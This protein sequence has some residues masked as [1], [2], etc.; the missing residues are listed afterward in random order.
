MEKPKFNIGKGEGT[1]GLNNSLWIKKFGN[2][3]KI[4]KRGQG[5][6]TFEVGEIWEI[7]MYLRKFGKRMAFPILLT[8]V[9]MI[10]LWQKYPETDEFM[11]RL[12]KDEVTNEEKEQIRKDYE[13]KKNILESLE[14]K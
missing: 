2:G 6:L 13:I 9:D 14:E 8:A 12:F 5:E 10:P 7:A 3:V 11:Q 1:I 4:R